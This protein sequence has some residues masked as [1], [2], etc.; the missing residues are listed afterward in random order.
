MLEHQP[1]SLAA[2]VDFE[3]TA[4]FKIIRRIGEGGTG[5]VYLAF[6]RKRGIE[7]AL[8]TLRNE[9]PYGILRLKNE[10]RGLAELARSA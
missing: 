10:F 9:S 4:R 1:R 3:G 6:D 8:K 5:Y 7:V 2:A